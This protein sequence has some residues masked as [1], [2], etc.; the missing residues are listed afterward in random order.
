MYILPL[1]MYIFFNTTF[2]SLW[3]TAN[4]ISFIEIQIYLKKQEKSNKRWSLCIISL[5]KEKM[6]LIKLRT[7]DLWE[8]MWRRWRE[9]I[10]TGRRCLQIPCPRKDWYLEYRK[11]FQNLVVRLQQ[12]KNNA[13]R[14]WKKKSHELSFHW[15]YTDRKEVHEKVFNII[16]L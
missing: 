11:H 7:F 13:I 12:H 3:D 2:Q 15:E 5:I 4:A 14:K 6:D 10:Q 1:Y 9:K 16:S 8:S